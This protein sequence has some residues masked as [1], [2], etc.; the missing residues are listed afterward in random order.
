MANYL[1]EEEAEN[2]SAADYF[3]TEE[4]LLDRTFNRPTKELLE[5]DN[6]FIEKLTAKEIKKLDKQRAQKYELLAKRL[7]REKVRI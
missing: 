1:K 7:M 6:P 2:F 3:N 4:D 5:Q